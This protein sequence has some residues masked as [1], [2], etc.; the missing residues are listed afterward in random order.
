MNNII[1]QKYGGTSV[2]TT[3]KIKR[4][5]DRI[6]SF[7]NQ[8]KNMV[9]IVSA[10]GDTTDDLIK[11]AKEITPN[12]SA[13]EMDA[14]ISTGESISAALLAMAIHAKGVDAI[15]LTGRQAGVYT[16]DAYNKARVLDV[17]PD[18]V[19]Q[20]LNSGKIVI[21]TGFQGVNSLDDITTIGRGGSDT[22]AVI[23]A[24]ALK[25]ELCEI[26]TDVDGVYTTNP[27]LI[28]NARKLKTISYDEMLEMAS[29]GAQVLHPRSVE[30]AKHYK[31][32]LHVR[33][34]YN[35]NEGTIVKEVSPMEIKNPVTG[36]AYDDN[37]AKIAIQGLPDKPGVAGGFFTLLADN[38]VN[39]DMII[40]SNQVDQYN[41]IAFTVSKDDFDKTI[42]L[43]KQYAKKVNASK[44]I[45]D[46]NIAK[47]SIIGVGMISQPGVAARMFSML[48]ENGIN[49]DLISTS[50]IKVSCIINKK[51]T[52]K[53]VQVLH[54]GFQLEKE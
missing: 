40:Q 32:E 21:V 26:Y 4:V 52:E 31:M 11:L 1:V 24:A 5:A 23:I 3:D 53:A 28:K 54:D 50:E 37:T 13:R 48:G 25:A 33:S 30:G 10:M 38:K 17:K 15:S 9:V 44:V 16:E 49:I 2:G 20:E 43:T 36:I 51:Y 47:I 39:V 7:K 22:S 42:E 19:Q 12:P 46:N 14:L 6:I 18:R 35:F 27:N 8:G 41:D 29:L 34:S 45:F